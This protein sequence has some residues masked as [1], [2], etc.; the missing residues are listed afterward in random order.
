MS[1]KTREAMQSFIPFVDTFASSQFA[2]LEVSSG[3]KSV[4]I[5]SSP[6]DVL[7]FAEAFVSLLRARLESNDP[8]QDS[9]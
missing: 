5:H 7:V 2:V 8:G 1:R 3:G 4:R 9:S 6:A